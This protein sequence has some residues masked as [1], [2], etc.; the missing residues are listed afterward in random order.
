MLEILPGEVLHH[1]EGEA[2]LPVRAGVE[3][4][5]DVL[6]VNRPGGPGL[7]LKAAD[8][9]RIPGEVARAYHLDGDATAGG[10][11]LRFVDGA[12]RAC[13]KEARDVVLAI[14]RRADHAVTAHSTG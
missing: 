14:E 6:G 5:R 8:R 3:H 1:Q 10:G 13:T 9:E 2:A 12:H 7:A 11:V 4:L